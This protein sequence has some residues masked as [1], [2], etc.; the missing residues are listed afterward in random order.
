MDDM[1]VPSF[2]VDEDDIKKDKDKMMQKGFKYFVHE[3]LKG[4]RC[5]ANAKGHHQEL[6]MASMSEKNI[7]RNICLLHANLVIAREEID[8]GE[9]LSTLELIQKVIN[10]KNGKCI[11]DCQFVQN[12]DVGT[13]EPSSFFLKDHDNR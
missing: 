1:G 9:D 5:I 3:T 13:H 8:F 6:V 10:D 7:V 2:T 11:L 4:G 12:S